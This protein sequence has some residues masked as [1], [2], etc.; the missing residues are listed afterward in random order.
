MTNDRKVIPVYDGVISKKLLGN[1]ININI[2][3]SP[4]LKLKF[5]VF[6]FSGM[7]LGVFNLWHPTITQVYLKNYEVGS[8][9]ATSYWWYQIVEEEK[10]G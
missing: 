6:L 3:I 5:S 7:Q 4:N 9:S 1:T 2:I 10:E 8:P